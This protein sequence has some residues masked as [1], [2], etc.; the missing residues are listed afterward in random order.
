[1][2]HLELKF[3]LWSGFSWMLNKIRSKETVTRV[4]RSF[5]EIFSLEQQQMA[6]IE[7]IRKAFAVCI[8]LEMIFFTA[9]SQDLTVIVQV[10]SD[11]IVVNIN[12]MHYAVTNPIGIANCSWRETVLPIR[13]GLYIFSV[14]NPRNC[15]LEIADIGFCNNWRV[16]NIIINPNLVTNRPAV[17]F[18]VVKCHACSLSCLLCIG[19][20]LA[21]R[22][23][24][25]GRV[26]GKNRKIRGAVVWVGHSWRN[27]SL[28]ISRLV[29]NDIKLNSRN[30]CFS[31]RPSVI[32]K[33][34]CKPSKRSRR[35]LAAW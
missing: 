6:K 11:C 8:M 26:K 12:K 17:N 18:C 29:V 33:F 32:P 2:Y 21:E 27:P 25:P 22:V 7:V 14:N 3:W 10:T 15:F 19:G 13:M 16:E 9:K 4:W 23:F 30:A 28:A 35:E 1:M 31:V 34:L 24:S 20:N 5:F